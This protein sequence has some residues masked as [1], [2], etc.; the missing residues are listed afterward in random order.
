MSRSRK[1][2]SAGTW[3][4][5]KSQKRGKQHCNRKFRRMEHVFIKLGVFEMLPTHQREVMSQWD[6]GGDGKRYY[7]YAPDEVWYIKAMRK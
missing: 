3:C 5:C 1:R 6:L 7:G 2:T 4:C